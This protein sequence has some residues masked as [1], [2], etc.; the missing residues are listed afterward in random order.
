MTEGNKVY[1]SV[2]YRSEKGILSVGRV[3]SW[4]SLAVAQ[5][6]GK[7]DGKSGFCTRSDS[8]NTYKQVREFP[9]TLISVCTV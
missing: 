6:Q 5:K 2:R 9:L 1:V 8:M 4:N 3:S 7:G